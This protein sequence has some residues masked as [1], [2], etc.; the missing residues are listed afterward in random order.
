MRQDLPARRRILAATVVAASLSLLVLTSPPANA[1]T[2]SKTVNVGGVVLT[3]STNYSA[4]WD[5][6]LRNDVNLDIA[7]N[8]VPSD[9]LDLRIL[10]GSATMH[11]NG[12]NYLLATSAPSSLSAKSMVLTSPGTSSSTTFSF[13]HTFNGMH[14]QPGQLYTAH[15][16][17][18][19]NMM[20]EVGNGST[21]STF[22]NGDSDMVISLNTS[23]PHPQPSFL[24]LSMWELLLLLVTVIASTGAILLWMSTSRPDRLGDTSASVY[25]ALG[26]GPCLWQRRL[27]VA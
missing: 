7:L 1:S 6:N 14:A 23:N 19:L 5:W 13:D 10:D 20:V 12:T 11:Q 17:V 22:M 26:V 24:G 4:A 21:L 3:V 9:F 18:W 25:G 16:L 15:I 2:Y 8:S 27:S